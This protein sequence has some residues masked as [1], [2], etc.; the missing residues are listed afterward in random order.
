MNEELELNIKIQNY[1]EKIKD[2]NSWCKNDLINLQNDLSNLYEK[3]EYEI[4]N[5]ENYHL[6]I[7][8]KLNEINSLKKK[9]IEN[10]PNNNGFKIISP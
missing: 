8:K 1:E 10:L 6:L 7:S 9:I 5:E 3:L 2:L 4:K